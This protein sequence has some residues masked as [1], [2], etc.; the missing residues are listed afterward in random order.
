MFIRNSYLR[1]QFLEILSNSRYSGISSNNDRFHLLT[2]LYKIIDIYRLRLNSFSFLKDIDR[3]IWN[4]L[5]PLSIVVLLQITQKRQTFIYCH[6]SQNFKKKLYS[7][8]IFLYSLCFCLQNSPF[9]LCLSYLVCML[10]CSALWLAYIDFFP[11]SSFFS[12]LF[13]Y[14]L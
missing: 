2:R 3:Q 6:C 13:S 1:K 9:L 11:T 12:E 5:S 8:K 4:V 7:F 14:S 10:N